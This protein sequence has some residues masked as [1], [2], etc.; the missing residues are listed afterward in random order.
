MTIKLT[1]LKEL[2][3][4]VIETLENGFDGY[5]R[6]IHSE[7]FNSD[8]TYVYTQDAIE[9]LEDYG[10]FTAIGEVVEYEKDN[11]GEVTTDL[12]DPTKVANMMVYILGE[13]V[14]YGRDDD[15]SNKL[16][17]V[18]DYLADDDTNAELVAL[19]KGDE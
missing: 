3:D 6:D 12:S 2:V 7:V 8:Y 15:F 17:S 19:L 13:S 10:T 9:A 16:D 14:I 5:Y 18:W 1:E 11:F 4:M